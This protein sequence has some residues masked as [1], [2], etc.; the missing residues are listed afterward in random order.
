LIF[1][2]SLSLSG[3]RLNGRAKE[4]NR[5]NVEVEDD[6]GTTAGVDDEAAGA[7]EVEAV[8]RCLPKGGA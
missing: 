7:E 1:S 6:E 3:F 4:G 2:F 8:V 5:R